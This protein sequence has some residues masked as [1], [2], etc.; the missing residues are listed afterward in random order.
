ML[1][2]I[3]FMDSRDAPIRL[4]GIQ[5]AHCGQGTRTIGLH[6][7]AMVSSAQCLSFVDSR[8][9]KFCLPSPRRALDARS[10]HEEAG[11]MA[12]ALSATCHHP[13]TKRDECDTWVVKCVSFQL[14]ISMGRLF[15][16]HSNPRR[17]SNSSGLRVLFLRFGLP[18]IL[19]FLAGLCSLTISSLSSM[20]SCESS[21]VPL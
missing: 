19:V 16:H 18:W 14:R 17:S 20:S 3:G 13:Q 6:D 10:L 15:V 4:H 5:N 21:F 9:M 7:T 12:C 1:K 2:L 11:R 8:Q